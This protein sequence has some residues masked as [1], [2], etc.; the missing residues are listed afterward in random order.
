MTGVLVVP[1]FGGRLH[2]LFDSCLH[3]VL[4]D[5]EVRFVRCC[6]SAT[7]LATVLGVPEALDNELYEFNFLLDMPSP[8]PSENTPWPAQTQIPDPLSHSSHSSPYKRSLKRRKARDVAPPQRLSPRQTITDWPEVGV[9]M[10]FSHE[11]N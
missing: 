2:H 1:L 5:H 11:S 7:V 4:F 9:Y 6:T 10:S 3:I 8:S